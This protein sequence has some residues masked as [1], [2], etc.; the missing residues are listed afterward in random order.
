MRQYYFN[1]LAKPCRNVAVLLFIMFFAVF[2]TA[3]RNNTTCL[4]LYWG[5]R[6]A[7]DTGPGS[8]TPA[9][10]YERV[11]IP[12]IYGIMNVHG[13]LTWMHLNPGHFEGGSDRVYIVTAH[14]PDIL[15]AEGLVEQIPPN[16]GNSFF[17]FTGPNGNVHVRIEAGPVPPSAATSEIP[18]VINLTTLPTTGRM[19]IVNA[20]NI[21]SLYNVALTGRSD[22]GANNPIVDVTAGGILRMRT[23]SIVRNSGWRGVRVTGP[24]SIFNMYSDSVVGGTF[25]PALPPIGPWDGDWENGNIGGVILQNGAVGFMHSGSYIRGNTATVAGG[26]VRMESG[27][28]FHMLG[29]AYITGNSAPSGGGVGLTGSGAG[30]NFFMNT[31]ATISSNRTTAGAGGGVQVAFPNTA[32]YNIGPP[33]T[34]F[35]NVAPPGSFWPA[36]NI[37]HMLGGTIKG[38]ESSGTGGG[39]SLTYSGSHFIMQSGTIY[40]NEAGGSGGGVHMG[41]GSAFIM[42]GGTIYNNEATTHGGGVVITNASGP[43]RTRFYMHGGTIH[44]NE[45]G[46]NGGGV[47]MT[48][49]SYLFMFNSVS[50]ENNRA[51]AVGGG[52]SAEG[53][54]RITMNNFASIQG[55]RAGLGATHHGGGVRL[56]GNNARLYMNNM[57]TIQNN[58]AGGDGGGVFLTGGSAADP[59]IFTMN[60]TPS[61]LYNTAGVAAIDADGN[62]TNFHP[63]TGNGGGV[64]SA[65]TQ[66]NFIMNG[67]TIAG[68]SAWQGG[69]VFTLAGAVGITTININGGSIRGGFGSGTPS[70]NTARNPL[71]ASHAM[72]RNN[73]RQAWLIN[74]LFVAGNATVFNGNIE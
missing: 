31:G 28:T 52:V 61:I 8:G 68:N 27:S 65:T 70:Y 13:Q 44:N 71:Q 73:A 66:A 39:V 64:H 22:T 7:S 4:P 26:G 47:S 55:N 16:N 30:S 45:A 5:G 58:V 59:L 56:F 46:T 37:F 10:S 14:H 23:G 3:C 20:D 42:N 63:T 9:P 50:I 24:G 6:G 33:V 67:G 43:R 11:Y 49:H 54:G 35:P 57:T 12:D 60:G 18:R 40:N 62:I 72:F 69:G 32:S 41:T 34:Y 51:N 15:T 21:L 53:N 38:N 1:N 17:N 29:G 36:T 2:F 19:F 25:N 74:T 48:G